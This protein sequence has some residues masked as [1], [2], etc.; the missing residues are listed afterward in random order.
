L[1]KL[2]RRLKDFVRAFHHDPSRSYQNA[3]KSV[4]SFRFT[5]PDG[6]LLHAL[7]AGPADTGRLPVVCLPGL[8]RTAEDF[9]EVVEKLAFDPARP[10]RV[11]ALDS[12]GRGLSA[13][14][15]KPENYAVP[16][17]LGDVFALLAATDIGRAIFVGTS[18]GGILTM[19]M[20]SVRPE[21][22]A[23]AVLNDIGP[24]LDMPGLVRIKA[25]VG[26]LPAPRDYADAA[27]MLRGAM[28]NQF[29]GWSDATWDRYARL[30]WQET[31][32]GL[33]TRYDPA[34]SLTLAAIDPATPFPPLW[35]AF[36]ALPDVPLMVIRGEH[37]DLL[38]R[39]TVAAMQ[40]R[41]PGLETI[42]IAGEGHA[43]LLTGETLLGRIA[44]FVARCD[45]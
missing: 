7:A 24:V 1:L 9:R 31:S 37:S 3:M 2:P 42:E 18:R 19:V 5:A 23:G 29:P 15:P 12:R 36:D 32:S 38:S 22:I 27:R 26:R 10:R 16:V 41:R 6:L 25:Y 34:L 14:D 17:E 4:D 30:T 43:P 28:G 13:R 39:E 40:A 45:G 11:L 44:R 35:D 8:A 20:A 21:L 33:V